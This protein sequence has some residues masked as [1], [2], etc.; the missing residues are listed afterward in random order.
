[1]NMRLSGIVMEK[2]IEICITF[3]KKVMIT[4]SITSSSQS[5][6]YSPI[7]AKTVIIIGADSTGARG[8]FAPLLFRV[9][10]REYPFAPLPFV[11][12]KFILLFFTPASVLLCKDSTYY[13]LT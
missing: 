13:Q 5:N 1:M 11:L 12:K 4:F 6:D 8:I 3:C 9:G 10:G 7:I 2:V